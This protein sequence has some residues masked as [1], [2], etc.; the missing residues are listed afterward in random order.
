MLRVTTTKR[1]KVLEEI[2]PLVVGFLESMK[3]S[4]SMLSGE[5]VTY[6]FFCFLDAFLEPAAISCQLFPGSLT[7]LLTAHIILCNFF[8]EGHLEKTSLIK[9]LATRSCKRSLHLICMYH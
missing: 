3:N 5:A 8:K 2:I 6:G 9:A 1:V 4:L 7:I